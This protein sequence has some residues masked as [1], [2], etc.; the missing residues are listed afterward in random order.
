MAGTAMARALHINTPSR[1]DFSTGIVT[2][3]AQPMK[4]LPRLVAL[5][6]RNSFGVV[7]MQE[8]SLRRGRG[9]ITMMVL[10]ACILPSVSYGG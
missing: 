4:E 10:P 8:K 5:L 2:A 3:I 1:L 7:V 9:P 6:G